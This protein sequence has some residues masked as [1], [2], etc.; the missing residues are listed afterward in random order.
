M[1]NTYMGE[2]QH[3]FNQNSSRRDDRIAEMNGSIDTQESSIKD[4]HKVDELQESCLNR[5]FTMKQNLYYY[6]ICMKA[7]LFYHKVQK[8]KNRLAAYTRNKIH[9]GKMRRLFESWRAVSHQEFK[10]RMD[11]E[12]TNFRMELES[13]MLVKW[14]TK[15][16]QLLVYMQQLEDKIKM[17]QDARERLTV[18]YDQSLNSGFNKL[19]V[20]TQV[21]SANPL[22][23]EVIIPQIPETNESETDFEADVQ[24]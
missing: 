14:S 15:V 20:E 7:W 10:E 16:D 5:F 19:N 1:R 21:L 23:H 4:L 3:N 2:Y 22:V 24:I 11:N 6:R 9:R 8:R 17:E 18:T 12:K 13:K